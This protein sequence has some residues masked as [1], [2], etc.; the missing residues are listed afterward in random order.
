MAASSSKGSSSSKSSTGGGKASNPS[1]KTASKTTGSG[2]GSGG[3]GGGGWGGSKESSGGG[4]ASSPAS[5]TSTASKGSSNKDSSS[6][7]RAS[8]GGGKAS[9]PATK[10]A[11]ASAKKASVGG[12]KSSNP[13]SKTT[14][15]A[16]KMMDSL[17]KSLSDFGSAVNAGLMSAGTQIRD[18][19][20]AS[21]TPVKGLGG[22]KGNAATIA[23]VLQ[24][25]GFK[26]HQI[27]GALGRLSV[28]SDLR[29][30]AIRRK[31]NK[32]YTGELADSVGIGQWNGPRQLAL[33]NFAAE[34]GT[35]WKDVATQARFFAHEIRTSPDEARAW[36][37]MQDSTDELGAAEAMMHYERPQNYSA[38]N[39]TAGMHWS[40]TAKRTAEF[41]SSLSE[42]SLAD[43]QS[44]PSFMGT[45]VN[46]V[47]P[48]AK[49]SQSVNAETAYSDPYV[50]KESGNGGSRAIDAA[51]S[52]DSVKSEEEKKERLGLGKLTDSIGK[53][54]TKD[55]IKTLV[56]AVRDPIGFVIDSIE[57]GINQNGGFGA[58]LAGTGEGYKDVLEPT[59][60][61]LQEN[62]KNK[63]EENTQTAATAPVTP[64]AVTPEPVLT[65]SLVTGRKPFWWSELVAGDKTKFIV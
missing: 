29:P 64:V 39:P 55:T 7:A 53:K 2:T 22:L 28:E 56:G 27:S 9:N 62:Q 46:A 26:P 63:N 41:A 37:T 49:K 1:S 58:N 4:K 17:T 21:A 30:D 35:D 51:T 33:K 20:V 11:T 65:T 47:S 42:E 60:N 61:A 34:A 5:K 13:A 31:D 50:T 43:V 19:A 52:G 59:R 54:N 23:K 38:K 36:K 16:R 14:A 15:P 40:K 12:G 25:E 44:E 8:V 24:E 6:S 57:D 45:L 10:T 18:A 48:S 32:K 3:S